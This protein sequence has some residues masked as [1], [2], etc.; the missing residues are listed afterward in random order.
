MQD[1]PIVQNLLDRAEMFLR[2][3]MR[4]AKRGG[5]H[6]AFIH[7]A[8]A[9]ANLDSVVNLFGEGLVRISSRQERAIIA[10]IQTGSMASLK[11]KLESGNGKPNPSADTLKDAAN[12]L[13]EKFRGIV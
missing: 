12:F 3:G 9:G 7:Y 4:S 8:M 2:A 13:L 6:I 11:L 5:L 1:D 10:L